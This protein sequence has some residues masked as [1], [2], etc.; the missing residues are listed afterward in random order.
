M[1]MNTEEDVC[2][3]NDVAENINSVKEKNSCFMFFVLNER[4]HDLFI[5][6]LSK[7]CKICINVFLGG[8]FIRKGPSVY[9]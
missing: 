8:M 7:L 2:W 3:P 1:D 9:L 6:S 4:D 5:Q